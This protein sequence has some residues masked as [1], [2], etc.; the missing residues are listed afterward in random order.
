[1]GSSR[2]IDGA[3]VVSRYSGDGEVCFSTFGCGYEVISGVTRAIDE[4]SSILEEDGA[5]SNEAVMGT[6]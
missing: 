5:V 6:T 3:R 1:M 2:Y 4:V